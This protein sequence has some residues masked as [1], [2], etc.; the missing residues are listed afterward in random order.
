M[1]AT[2]G[3]LFA[4]CEKPADPA[5]GTPTEQPGQGGD[6]QGDS[7]PEPLG[8]YSFDGT[9]YDL[10]TALYSE[11][12]YACYFIF[13]PLSHAQ[14]E[15]LTTYFSLVLMKYFVGATQNVE[16]MYHNHDYYFTYE[17][18]VRFY[19]HYR[20]LQSGVMRVQE[21]GAGVFRVMLDIRLIDG[22]PLTL[23]YSGTFATE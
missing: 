3:L 5:P 18:P 14:G 19:S 15:T 6:E 4:A 2:V 22:T 20:S 13:S 23:D 21:L 8:S 10:H 9:E 16:Q 17:D 11:D 7:Y 1:L 12:D